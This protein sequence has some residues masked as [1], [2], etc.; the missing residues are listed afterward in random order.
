[1]RN[2][3]TPVLTPPGKLISNFGLF[4]HLQ[5]ITSELKYRSHVPLNAATETAKCILDT[6]VSQLFILLYQC[7]RTCNVRVQD[8]SK[9]AR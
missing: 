1:M 2:Q 3:E 7:G 6:L 8:D 9:F 5:G 4:G